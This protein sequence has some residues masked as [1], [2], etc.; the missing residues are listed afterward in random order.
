MASFLKRGKTWQYSISRMV[1][2][3][4]KP[5]RKGGFKTKKEAQVAAAEV[6]ANMRK[7]V[8]PNLKPVSF[9]EYLEQFINVYK[10]DI[11]ENTLKRYKNTLNTVYSYFGHIPIQDIKKSDYQEFLNDYGK[12]HAKE[13]T[14]KLNIHIR[15]CV[16]EAI[17]EGIIFKDFT[18]DAKLKGKDSK[19]P[20]E[21]HLNY[22]EYKLLLKEVYK[23][24]DQGMTYYIILL[25]LTTGMRYSEL[26]GLTRRDINFKNNTIK[27]NKTWDYKG[28]NKFK[29][30]KNHETRVIKVNNKTMRVFEQL[31]EK[32]PDNIHQLVFYSPQSKYKVYTSASLNKVLRNLLK[33][34]NIEQTITMHGLRHT[35]ASV[36]LYLRCSIYYVS[37]R[38]GHKDTQTTHIYY[39]HVIKE[40]RAE[41]E[42]KA[43]K[44]I[45]QMVG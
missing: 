3:K 37:E 9:S 24:L 12:T 10:I 43:T 23:R 39:A 11:D 33:V 45:D 28:G 20:E 36:L 41:D 30:T 19:R 42:Q 14:R 1:G 34:L 32:V 25:A 29:D 2:G 44:T 13:S 27:I 15:A 6:E 4:Y 8:I 7:G 35:H 26:V 38:L 40:L 22:F 21:K 16:R 5:I 17:D 18:R 31:F